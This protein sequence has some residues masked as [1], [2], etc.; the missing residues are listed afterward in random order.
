[1]VRWRAC[2]L[3]NVFERLES[4]IYTRAM[5]LVDPRP[6][7]GEPVSLELLNTRWRSGDSIRD[8]L[9]EPDGLA[10]WLAVTGLDERCRA[11]EATL[12]ALLEA[13]E[14]LAAATSGE[15]G[16]SAEARAALNSVLAHGRL[17]REL[18][19][20]GPVETVEMDDPSWLA[21]WSA[22]DDYLSLVRR[23]PDR[24]RRC[25]GER[26]VLHFFDTSQ[27][28]RRRWCSMATCGNRDKASRHYARTRANVEG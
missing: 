25:A 5:A 27:N 24:I 9:A 1:M 22:A 15:A 11:D 4:P 10:L 23:A 12:A 3:I 8:L 13:R 28:G 18:T 7:T 20:L 16:P 6:L 2:N 14:A 19:E 26:C 21:A 17:R